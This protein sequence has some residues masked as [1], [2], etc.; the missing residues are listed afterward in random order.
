MVSSQNTGCSPTAFRAVLNRAIVTGGIL[1]VMCILTVFPCASTDAQEFPG[2]EKDPF[3]YAWEVQFREKTIGYSLS[4]FCS[5]DEGDEQDL[6]ADGYRSFDFEIGPVSLR[7]TE[8]TRVVWDNRGYM[9]EMEA[10]TAVGGNT[11]MTRVKRTT[12]GV[13]IVKKTDKKEKEFFF[14]GSEYDHT[15]A[16][17]FLHTLSDPGEK[18]TL[19]ILSIT[20]EKVKS[21]SYESLG[22]TDFLVAGKKLACFRVGFKGPKS[23]GEMLVDALGIPVFFDMDTPLGPF[24][25]VPCDPDVAKE[26][27]FTK[28]AEF[29]D[30]P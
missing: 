5:V 30:Y 13:S 4:R 14:A 3:D 27:L 11:T 8:Q 9:R 20:E 7:V 1:F 6:C 28:E 23:T 18:E 29:F 12:D 21:I 15:E 16:D 24:T 26:I 19:R 10:R 2:G 17:R 25:F 22:I